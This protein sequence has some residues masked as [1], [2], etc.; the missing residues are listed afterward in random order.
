MSN[1]TLANHY[2]TNFE[3]MYHHNMSLTEFNSMLPYERS[4]YVQLLNGYLE[5]RNMEIKQAQ[6]R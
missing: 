2:N 4:I 3:L 6:N 1:D 5:K